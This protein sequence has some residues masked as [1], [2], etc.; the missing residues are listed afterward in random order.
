MIVV[1]AHDKAQQR[2]SELLYK[3]SLYGKDMFRSS[4]WTDIDV[5]YHFMRG[6]QQGSN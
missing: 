5:N 1:A 4:L 3:N 2:Y 6:T